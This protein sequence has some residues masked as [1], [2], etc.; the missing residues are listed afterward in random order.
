MEFKLTKEEK[1]AIAALKRI[2]KYWPKTLWVFCTGM[3][4]NIMRCKE[5]GDHAT[6]PDVGSFRGG[7]MDPDYVVDT[8]N[9][10]NDGGDW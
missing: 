2:E 6:C 1:C 8:V 5:D 10:P 4:M 9:I 3:S 7:G